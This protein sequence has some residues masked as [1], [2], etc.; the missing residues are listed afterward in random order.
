MCLSFTRL[1]FKPIEYEYSIYLYKST[2]STN[3]EKR[4]KADM[5]IQSAMKMMRA[6]VSAYSRVNGTRF[7]RV[8]IV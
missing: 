7:W 4:Q 1:T 3:E 2:L 5:S 6:D 8:V